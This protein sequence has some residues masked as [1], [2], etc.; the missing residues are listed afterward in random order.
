[1]IKSAFQIGPKRQKAKCPPAPAS[2]RGTPERRAYRALL[3]ATISRCLAELQ[4][5]AEEEE[6]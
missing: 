5:L 2:Y 1:M 6:R 3:V 4:R